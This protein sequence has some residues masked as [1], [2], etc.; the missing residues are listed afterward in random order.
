MTHNGKFGHKNGLDCVK[1]AN[2]ACFSIFSDLL[3]PKHLIFGEISKTSISG[4]VHQPEPKCDIDLRSELF[5]PGGGVH[6]PEPKC[7]IDLRSEFFIPG[8]GGTV[9]QNQNVTLT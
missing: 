2:L 8:G 5:I 9:S 4:G 6:Q 3:P 1:T 7:H